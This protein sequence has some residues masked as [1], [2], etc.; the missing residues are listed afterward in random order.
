MKTFNIKIR[1][2]G[3]VLCFSALAADFA[4]AFHLAFAAVAEG[5]SFGIVVRR[6][7]K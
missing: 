4:G 2:S 1:Q 6:A 5:V 3:R 7:L